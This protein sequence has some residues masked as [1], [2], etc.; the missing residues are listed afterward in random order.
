[1]RDDETIYSSF[2]TVAIRLHP[3]LTHSCAVIESYTTQLIVNWVVTAP[4]ATANHLIFCLPLTVN[5][6]RRP[7]EGFRDK[8]EHHFIDRREGGVVSS[9][10]IM[11]NCEGKK[12]D[13]RMIA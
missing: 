10:D 1:V 5:W 3:N 4:G 6:S 7:C 9:V 8:V 2:T 11:R 12:G 13:R